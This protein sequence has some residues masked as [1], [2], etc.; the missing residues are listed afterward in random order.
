MEEVMKDASRNFNR[1]YKELANGRMQRKAK[2]KRDRAKGALAGMV[3]GDCLGSPVEFTHDYNHPWITKMEPC[4]HWFLPK[5]C[6]TDDSALGF[7]IM[8]AFIDH[9]DDFDVVHVA[10]AF[11]KWLYG[12]QWSS[13]PYPFG[14]GRDCGAGIENFVRTGSL[15]N[16]TEQSQGNGTVMRF[17]PS[18]FVAR[19]V[20]SG[21]VE[22]AREIEFAISDI[23][24]NSSVTRK[25][26][27][28]LSS[29]LS[30]HIEEGKKTKEDS[31]Y[32]ERKFVNNSGWCISTVEAALWAFK[33]THNFRDALVAAVNLGGDADT[34]GDV[35]GQIAG[36]YYGFS[37]IP[38]TWLKDIKE[39][40]MVEEFIDEFLDAT[41]VSEVRHAP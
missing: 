36:S 19:K 17:A 9:K 30:D 35:C 26:V 1:Q 6:W 32:V 41:G 16:G 18:W 20:A 22:K 13:Q 38:K 14:I 3:V 12:A 7:N 8:Q 2:D 29:I 40:S 5:G 34:I 31:I 21:D 39:W 33:S 25:A 24:H 28:K 37:A 4:G 11:A 23:T 15:K 10:E 27:S